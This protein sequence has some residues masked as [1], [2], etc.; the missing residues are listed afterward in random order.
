MAM[1]VAHVGEIDARQSYRDD[2]YSSM[3]AFCE[4]A[5]ELSEQAALKRI[6]VA[7]VARQFPALFAGLA[8]GK[9]SL[10]SVLVLAAHLTP[11]NADDLIAAAI[12]VPKSELEQLISKRFPKQDVP[13]KLEAIPAPP[14]MLGD[15]VSPATV[16]TTAGDQ[17][18]PG[19]V[20]GTVD[21]Q[22][23]SRDTE[24]AV[25]RSKLLP[26]SEDRFAL[27]LTISRCTH[28]KL[29]YAQELL[30]HQLPSGDLA[31][32]FDRA[33]DALIVKLEKRK[34]AATS[35]PRRSGQ[36]STKSPRHI[37]ARVKREVWERDGG[38]CTF[39]SESG[40]RCEERKFLEF[41]HIEAVARGGAA[42]CEGA[43]RD[44]GARGGGCGRGGTARRGSP[45]GRGRAALCGSSTSRSR[46]RTR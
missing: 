4:H 45:T 8:S 24:T 28:D 35:Q 21:D 7:R 41:D 11:G 2:G 16:G 25:P 31:E 29:R 40:H 30:S 9:L 34:F 22:L 15:Q 36:R 39:V 23:S 27:Q 33:L 44:E 26:L 17:L 43:A 13:A 5:L 19:T 32:V 42:G 20:G 37:P 14:P 1:A 6:R 3:F 18:S 12:Q 38:Q 46:S 10:S